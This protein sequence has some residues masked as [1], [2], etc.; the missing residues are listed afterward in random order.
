M[1][2]SYVTREEIC[3]LLAWIDRLEEVAGLK[4]DDAISIPIEGSIS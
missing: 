2:P 3:A 1:A 4:A